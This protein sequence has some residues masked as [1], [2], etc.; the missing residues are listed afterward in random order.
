MEE[1]KVEY[2]ELRVRG[3]TIVGLVAPAE[4]EE[5]PEQT[6]EKGAKKRATKKSAEAE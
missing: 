2:P 3:A 1:I 6:E 4:P 5:K